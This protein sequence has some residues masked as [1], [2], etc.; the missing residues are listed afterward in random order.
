MSDYNWKFVRLIL[1]WQGVFTII[2]ASCLLILNLVTAPAIAQKGQ[3]CRVSSKA[4]QE[5]EKLRLLA[6]K[7]NKEAGSRY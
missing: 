5:K 6:F 1:S 7:G 3:D 4:T 2:I